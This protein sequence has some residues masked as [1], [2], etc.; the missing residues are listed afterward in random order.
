MFTKPILILILIC[1]LTNASP[2]NKHY[3]IITCNMIGNLPNITITNEKLS[4]GL[5]RHIMK[6]GDRYT[7]DVEYDVHYRRY[8]NINVSRYI[9]NKYLYQTFILKIKY[10][11]QDI[12]IL[13]SFD[14][15]YID[16]K[17]YSINLNYLYL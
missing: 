11:N 8:E 5:L 15:E 4:N 9:L 6:L 2:I 17:K 10:Y 14:G 16:I 13:S 12:Y 3:D 7:Y 1:Y